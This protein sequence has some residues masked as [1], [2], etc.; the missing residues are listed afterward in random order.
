MASF[1]KGIG[2]AIGYI[3][4]LP[5]FLVALAIF[6]VY[7]IFVFIIMLFKSIMLFFQGKKIDTPIPEDIEAERRLHPVMQTQP[8]EQP[9]PVIVMEREPTPTYIQDVPSHP[10]QLSGNPTQIENRPQVNE[11]PHEQPV[12]KQ[13][14]NFEPMEEP[15]P[16]EDEIEDEYIDEP[17][18]ESYNEKEID[19][20]DDEDDILPESDDDPNDK[21]FGE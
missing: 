2:K 20:F 13:L 11:I 10:E 19:V 7:G 1:F 12:F 5:V 3:F 18:V 9:T 15:I 6:A 17:H 14:D 8:Q 21:I 4:V 16:H